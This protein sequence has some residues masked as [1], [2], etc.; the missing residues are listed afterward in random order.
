MSIKARSAEHSERRTRLVAGGLI[1]LGILSWLCYAYLAWLSGS[2]V[3]GPD[4]QQRP[5]LLFLATNAV[6]FVVYLLALAIAVRQHLGPRLVGATLAL[7]LTFRLTLL[8]SE[9]ILEIDIYRYIW[10]GTV[11]S[12]GVSPYRFSPQEV[13]E[14]TSATEIPLELQSLVQQVQ[15][16]PALGEILARVH[17]PEVRTVYPPTSQAVFALTSSL[18]PDSASLATRVRAMK[19][20]MLLFDAGIIVILLRLLHLAGLRN[21]WVLAYAWCPLVLKE[22]ANSGHLD[23]IA[24]MF[25]MAAIWLLLEGRRISV[26]TNLR[27]PSLSIWLIGAAVVCLSLGVGAKLFPIVLVPWFLGVVFQRWG[28][29]VTLAAGGLLGVFVVAVMSPM[30]LTDLNAPRA[31]AESS[32]TIPTGPPSPTSLADQGTSTGARSGLTTFLRY[33]EMNDFLFLIVVE[34]V[35]PHSAEDPKASAWFSV[36]PNQQREA[37]AMRFAGL[38]P[39]DQQEVSFHFTRLL[40][41]AAFAFV[42]LFYAVR[43]GSCWQS[44]QLQLRAA[45][46]TLA[47]FWL[48]SPTQNPWYWTWAIP[49]VPF[50]RSRAWLLVSGLVFVYYLRFWLLYHYADQPV[51]VTPY[52]GGLFFDFVVTW[53]EYGPWL[54]LLSGEGL[55]RSSAARSADI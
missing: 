44:P 14:A 51:L 21:G 41:L 23:S 5:V 4:H 39:L 3:Y 26:N 54:V 55:W 24:V 33:W 29:V 2:F 42:A 52:H 48:L 31:S 37:L 43:C 30:L 28:W 20:A 18:V 46:L 6:L 35:R 13:R 49:L 47:W 8:F 25:T 45:F 10:D 32:T 22:F 1:A 7:A 34:N 9:P 36:V 27:S 12:S 15:R 17:Y 16:S 53:L 50:A 38:I 19:F 11:A 40:T